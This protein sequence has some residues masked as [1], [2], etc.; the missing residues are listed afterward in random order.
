MTKDKIII[1]NLERGHY[2]K[3]NLNT[4]IV[5]RYDKKGNIVESTI[6]TSNQFEV[7]QNKLLELTEE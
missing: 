4:R 3:I 5:H 7:M 6:L 1:L 2:L